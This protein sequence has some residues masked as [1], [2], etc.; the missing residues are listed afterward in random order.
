MEKNRK[1]E[2]LSTEEITVL[3]SLSSKITVNTGSSTDRKIHIKVRGGKALTADE[4]NR[5]K[6]I[7]SYGYVPSGDH[8]N[9]IRQNAPLD[10]LI[11]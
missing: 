3:K 10:L 6:T 7:L 2:T 4:T 8:E 5:V 11:D 9:Y 1:K